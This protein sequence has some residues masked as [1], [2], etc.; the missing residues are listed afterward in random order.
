MTQITIQHKDSENILM[1]KFLQTPQT[2]KLDQAGLKPVY[3]CVCLCVCVCVCARVLMLMRVRACARVFM[4]VRGGFL[5]YS[6]GVLKRTVIKLNQT[7]HFS[8]CII[9]G[10]SL[11]PH[12]GYGRLIRIPPLRIA[13][14]L[15]PLR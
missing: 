15:V 13:L 9:T 8:F 10:L 5:I 2:V 3:L 11:R 1:P 6:E 4:F 12:H 7:F 14:G